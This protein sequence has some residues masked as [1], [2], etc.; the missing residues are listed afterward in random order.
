MHIACRFSVEGMEEEENNSDRRGAKCGNYDME[1]PR[2]K[3]KM[4]VGNLPFMHAG[5]CRRPDREAG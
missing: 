1:R 5:R 2:K 3:E 4:I